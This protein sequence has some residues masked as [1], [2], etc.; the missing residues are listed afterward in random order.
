[1]FKKIATVDNGVQMT[2]RYGG[3]S[4][5]ARIIESN[6]S[7]LKYYSHV[8]EF[9]LWIQSNDINGNWHFCLSKSHGINGVLY[10]AAI[11]I[12]KDILRTL[13]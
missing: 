4:R 1:M 12:Y 7:V 6:N 5:A 11:K 9:I 8:L 13:C 10:F 3:S 2:R